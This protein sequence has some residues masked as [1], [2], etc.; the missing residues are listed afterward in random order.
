MKH[1]ND[2]QLIHYH[3]QQSDERRSVEAH[4][5]CCDACRARYRALNDTLSAIALMP[6]PERP[7]EY[8]TRVWRRLR[9]RLDGSSP[10]LWR[11]LFAWPSLAGF[12][13]WWSAPAI[14]AA[15]LVAFLG[16]AFLT[17]FVSKNVLAGRLRQE[18]RAE[19]VADFQSA[20]RRS[21]QRSSNAMAVLEVRLAQ[22]PKEQARELAQAMTSLQ[23]R[24]RVEDREALF[25]LLRD[26]EEQ[27]TSAYVELR[28]ELEALAS[29]TDR[30]M[31]R[32]RSTW[33]ELAA[34]APRQEQPFG[35]EKSYR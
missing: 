31:R 17:H 20:L 26:W 33:F 21:E 9:P 4:L 32:A 2:E 8:G 11:R 18:L 35:T 6:V 25:A 7:A 34:H 30:E 13:R 10:S 28:Q 3:Y 22:A 24:A 19:L 1:L 5:A 14:T 16:G 29:S 23:G 27:N 12:P 15:V